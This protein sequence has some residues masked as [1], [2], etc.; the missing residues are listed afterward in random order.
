MYL[1]I[2]KIIYLLFGLFLEKHKRNNLNIFIF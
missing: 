2:S 1:V